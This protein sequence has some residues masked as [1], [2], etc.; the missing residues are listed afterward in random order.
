MQAMIFGHNGIVLSG[1]VFTNSRRESAARRPPILNKSISFSKKYIFWVV[2]H[3]YGRKGRF[4]HFPLPMRLRVLQLVTLTNQ[5]IG[6]R[7]C[8]KFK[9]ERINV[10]HRM[11]LPILPLSVQEEWDK[12]LLHIVSGY[13]TYLVCGEDYT[14]NLHV[15]HSFSKEMFE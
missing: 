12:R 2:E 9:F 7:L 11:G 5:Q 14:F 1:R 13:V 3:T 4:L 15:G 10:H 6:Q 8:P